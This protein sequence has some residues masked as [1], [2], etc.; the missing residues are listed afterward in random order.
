MSLPDHKPRVNNR[1]CN[2]MQSII[3]ALRVV[4]EGSDREVMDHI[5]HAQSQLDAAA[6]WVL[7]KRETLP[8]KESE[9]D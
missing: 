8:A 2:A 5:E 6:E 1:L 7:A 3:T 9:G 4:D